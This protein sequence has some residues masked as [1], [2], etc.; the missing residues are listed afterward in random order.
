MS[1]KIIILLA[2]FNGQNHLKSQLNSIQAQTYQNFQVLIRDDGST[3][4]SL[5]ILE[6]FCSLDPRFTLLNDSNLSSGTA[7]GNFFLL[8]N[9][10]KSYEFKY[11]ALSDQDDVWDPFKLEAAVGRLNQGY[12]GYSSN[13]LA[14]NND[15]KK[16]WYIIKSGSQTP[17]DYLF[18]GA[19]AGCT[20]VFSRRVLDVVKKFLLNKSIQSINHVSHDWLI[21]ALARGSGL[22]WYLDAD[23]YIFYRQHSNNVYGDAGFLGNIE[24]KFKLLTSG[25]Y[26]KNVLFVLES[27]EANE[28]SLIIKKAIAKN[29]FF[30]RIVLIKY[31][32]ISRRKKLDSSFFIILLILGFL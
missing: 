27:V 10:I 26:R 31:L 32:F 8:L 16:S 24:R 17:V 21:Y 22:S 11:V 18:Q 9:A 14:F 3:D 2:V 20:Y 28:H 12:D 6:E 23:S 4:E 7:A 15:K 30:A 13:L 29:N 19:S 25:W 5:K 1:S